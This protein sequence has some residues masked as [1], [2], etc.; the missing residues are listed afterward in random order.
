MFTTVP[1][2]VTPVSVAVVATLPTS[3]STV[4][5]AGSVPGASQTPTS[6]ALVSFPE[7]GSYIIYWNLVTS[8]GQTIIEQ[9]D[10]FAPVTQIHRFIRERL[11]ATVD[12]LPDAPLDSTLCFVNRLMIRRLSDVLTTYDSVPSVDANIFDQALALVTCAYLRPLVP[13]TYA[14][15]ELTS[16]QIGTDK[17]NFAELGSRAATPL[18]PVE[19]Q[20][21]DQAG[22]LIM[23]CS[24]TAEDDNNLVNFPLFQISGTRRNARQQLSRNNNCHPL[25]R[26]WGDDVS[27]F[28]WENGRKNQWM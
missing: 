22:E 9:D 10:Y 23:S 27:E 28:L 17:Y 6:S 21:I 19:Q 2:V 3:G 5:Y 18:D 11:S 1:D 13:K 24:F 26:L 4:T 20:W 25:Y 7:G 15:G 8:D 12:T 16:V 14:S